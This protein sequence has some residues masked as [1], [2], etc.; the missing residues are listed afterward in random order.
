LLGRN[1][2]NSSMSPS[3]DSREDREKRLKKR[4]GRKQ[5]GQQGHPGRTRQMVA[6]P[7]R[8]EVHWPQ[9]CGGCGGELGE[10]AVGGDP[11]VHQVSEIVVGVEV[12]E[13]RRMRVRCDCGCRTLAELPA[14]VPAGAFGPAVQAAVA[15]LTAARVSR[16]GTARPIED[17]CGL[18]LSLASVKA[19]VKQTSATLEEPYVSILEALDDAAVRG[20]GETIGRAPESPAVGVGVGVGVRAGR[21]V[22]D[23]RATR[24]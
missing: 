16:R 7:D 3:K 5:G 2:R 20:A 21:A 23:R 10:D 18:A 14:G 19:L 15:T 9:R 17:L 11:V 13:H 22:L 8:V 12:T 24:P 1:S 6:D 4:S